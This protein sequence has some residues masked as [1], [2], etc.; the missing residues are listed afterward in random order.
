VDVLDA[1]IARLDGLMTASGGGDAGG[2]SNSGADS[3]GGDAIDRVLGAAPRE[4]AVRGLRDDA[5]IQ[6]FRDE[7]A[8]GLIRADTAGRALDVLA[9]VVE[10]WV[11]VRG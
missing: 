3:G 11:S 4:T 8:D 6:R 9:R 1:L 5:S 2:E 7:L 10:R